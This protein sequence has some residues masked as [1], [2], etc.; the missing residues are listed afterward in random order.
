MMTPAAF[1][2][3]LREESSAVRRIQSGDM[4]VR[5]IAA[6]AVIAVGALFLAACQP[7]VDGS[8]AGGNVRAGLPLAPP[9]KPL[10][11]LGRDGTP[12]KPSAVE[13]SRGCVTAQ[14]LCCTG[15]EGLGHGR[16]SA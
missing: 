11:P 3:R 7:T 4:S 2:S 14:S 16:A 12:L 10:L 1:P 6:L 15:P 9:G 13:G 5:R 8:R